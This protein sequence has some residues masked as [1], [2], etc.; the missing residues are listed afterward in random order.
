MRILFVGDVVGKVGRRLLREQLKC[1]QASTAAD[2]TVVNIENAA[3]GFG[4]TAP[5]WD[6]LRRLPIDVF[7]SGNHIWDKKDT[8]P[9]LASQP[10][11]LRPANYPTGNPGRGMCTVPA[12]NGVQ[13][14]VMNLQG[15]TFMVPTES[16]FVVADRLFSELLI[17]DKV[18]LVD[19]HAEATSEK[20]ALAW[21][22][23]G[24]ASFVIG[25]HTHVPTADERILPRGTA[26]LTDA[27]MTGPYEG[28][29]GFQ[30]KEV[31]ERFLL[32]TPRALSPA[33]KGGALCGAVVDIDETTGRARAITRVRVEDG[34]PA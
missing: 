34:L 20:Q 15:V 30:P 14:T 4:I 22:L 29:I 23:D 5:I 26:A 19:F 2:F 17:S 32:V 25:T 16:P 31:L 3:G 28:I 9:L 33:T 8:L 24:R 11:L 12:R 21:Y 18:V 1:A 27:G 7:T 6:E 13:V 10:N